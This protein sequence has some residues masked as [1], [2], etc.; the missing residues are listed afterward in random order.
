MVVFVVYG[1]V[2]IIVSK[3]TGTP[4]YPAISWDSVETW[5]LGLCMLPLAAFYYIILY[6]LS[7]L[8]FRCMG[9]NESRDYKTIASVDASG[10]DI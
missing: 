10:N 2:N 5:I 4:V 9:M 6:F 8:K 1:C 7:K 3:A